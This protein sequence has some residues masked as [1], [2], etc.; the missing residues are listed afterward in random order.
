[1]VLH[2]EKLIMTKVLFFV[3][4]YFDNKYILS[5]DTPSALLSHADIC[6][7]RYQTTSFTALYGLTQSIKSPGVLIYNSSK[8]KTHFHYSEQFVFF[9]KI[10]MLLLSEV[11]QR[12]IQLTLINFLSDILIIHQHMKLGCD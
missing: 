9:V 2:K 5:L 10:I 11:L 3:L 12:Q 7:L 8:F 4:I 6:K 1:M